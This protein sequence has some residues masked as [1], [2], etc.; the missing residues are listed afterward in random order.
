[1]EPLY[2]VRLARKSWVFIVLSLV[3]A[4]AGA[5]VVTARTPAKY[6]ATISML[7]SGHD[8]EGSL[9]TALQAA[10]LSEQRIQSYASL[11]SS[12]RLIREVVPDDQIDEVQAAVKAEAIPAT[13]LLRASVTHTDP[14]RA[15]RLAN[16]LGTAFAKL[17]DHIERPTR[18]SDSTVKV[19]VVDE[20]EVPVTPVSPRPAVNLA[21]ALL[22]GLII[23]F[24]LLVLHDRLDTTIRTT[25]ALQRITGTPTLG[26]IE[27][28]R[29]ARRLP[30]IIRREGQ[31][32]RSEAFRSLRTNLQ[33]MGVDR[34]PRSLV[35]TSCLP[36][37]GKSST[38]TN[39]AITFAQAGWRVILVDADLRRPRVPSYL[40][41]E[42]A[43]GL[44]NVLIESVDLAGAVQTWGD[45]SLSV[46]PSGQIPANPS[47]LL[48]S[49]AMRDL[50]GR[51]TKEYDIVV[52]D[53]APLLPVTDAAALA[54][55]CDDVLLV[56]RHG[57]TRR[58]HLVRAG[59]LLSSINA[60][61]VGSV[62]NF[63]PPKSGQVYGYGA[64]EGYKPEDTNERP[65]LVGV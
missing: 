22:L 49:Q 16:S 29:D 59:E 9:S 28:E 19:T 4:G 17:I 7:V 63:V 11:L 37:E 50:V 46:L 34:Q 60:R 58:E 44:T 18:S 12:R 54:A 13:V 64:G 1:M 61:L 56:V 41:I 15:A 40:G 57:K 21:V 31:S 65:P 32:T 6:V 23:A 42:G 36:E 5:W 52:V 10:A 39:L 25:Q 38:A 48:G 51:L 62:L 30:L 3:L 14:L 20:A 26:I 27:Y 2:Y 55:I 43:V 45:D 47:E 35:V 24:S 8:N 33:F 53:A